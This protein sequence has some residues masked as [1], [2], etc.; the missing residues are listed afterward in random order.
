[1]PNFDKTGPNSEGAMT[2]RGM[3]KCSD[4]TPFVGGRRMGRRNRGNG[5]GRGFRANN[6]EAPS[7]SNAEILKRLEAIEEKLK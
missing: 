5:C 6:Q 2:G 7:A 3:G 4:D 1:M